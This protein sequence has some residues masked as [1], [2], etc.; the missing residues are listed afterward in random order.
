[1]PD[2][3][4][5]PTKDTPLFRSRA[6]DPE[7]SREAAQKANRGKKGKRLKDR[8][9]SS[10][11]DYPGG[12][13]YFTIADN[14]GREPQDISSIFTE[15]D[16]SGDI[17]RTGATEKGPKGARR[18]LFWL[19][20]PEGK[21]DNAIEASTRG[22]GDSISRSVVEHDWLDGSGCCGVLTTTKK[23]VSCN[24]CGAEFQIIP[25][26]VHENAVMFLKQ[27]ARAMVAYQGR[28]SADL[29]VAAKMMQG[30]K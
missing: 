3:Y 29:N 23:G 30:I 4:Q 27:G 16:R 24:E 2:P 7:T 12:V 28:L 26:H 15:L 13:S 9:L 6:D 14:I 1:M 11:K 18:L 5:Q 21:P 25:K 17:Y 22:R 8:I 10:M 19:T 20:P